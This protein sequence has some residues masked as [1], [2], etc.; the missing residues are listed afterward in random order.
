M[1]KRSVIMFNLAISLIGCA[2][3]GLV[4]GQLAFS[5]VQTKN[6]TQSNPSSSSS[7]SQLKNDRPII[8]KG[9]QTKITNNESQLQSVSSIKG[10]L[11]FIEVNKS[12]ANHAGI[13]WTDGNNKDYYAFLRPSS[14]RISIYNQDQKEFLSIPVTP[15]LAK[16]VWYTLGI[17]FSNNGFDV[18]LNNKPQIHVSQGN[19]SNSNIS[20]IGI[21]TYNDIAVFEPL[22]IAGLDGQQTAG[23]NGQ[24]TAGTNGQQTA[25]TNGQQTA[26]TN[27]QQTAGRIGQQT[28]GRIGQSSGCTIYPIPCQ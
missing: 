7:S 25:G 23:T 20:K 2:V 5:L 28:A 15:P 8:L 4:F 14:S 21:R 11:R 3:V 27:G 1:V 19:I 26:G 6:T 18:F 24:Q 13:V 22:Q 17:V 16:G 12:D 10:S 9:I